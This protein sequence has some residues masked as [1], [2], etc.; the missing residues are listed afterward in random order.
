MAGHRINHGICARYEHLIDAMS[1]DTIVEHVP[2]N[3]FRLRDMGRVKHY[4]DTVNVSD[5]YYNCAEK[6]GER[7]SYSN[8]RTIQELAV[9]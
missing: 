8:R 5:S 1:Y 7:L 9:S 2:L 4:A 6:Q 3:N